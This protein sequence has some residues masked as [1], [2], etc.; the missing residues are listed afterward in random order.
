MTITEKVNV[1]LTHKIFN[2][3]VLT[4]DETSCTEFIWIEAKIK[5]LVYSSVPFHFRISKIRYENKTVEFV[6]N[7]EIIDEHYNILKK[8]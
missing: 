6:T 1:I 7:R 3:E 8:D 2:Y 5:D 4:V